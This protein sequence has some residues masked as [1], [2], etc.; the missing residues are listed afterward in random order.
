MRTTLP[1]CI[2]AGASFFLL[3]GYEG[4][5]GEPPILDNNGFDLW[6]GDELCH[7]STD[8]GAVERVPTW[9]SGDVGGTFS[10]MRL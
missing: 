7:W 8:K 3:T 1:T 4:G 9:H 2:L 5:C 6:C 10:G